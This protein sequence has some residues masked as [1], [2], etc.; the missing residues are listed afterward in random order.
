[1][2]D[3]LFEKFL[4]RVSSLFAVNIFDD[5]YKASW[6]TVVFLSI[7]NANFVCFFAMLGTKDIVSVLHSVTC[8]NFTL[9]VT[10]QW[11]PHTSGV[12]LI[13]TLFVF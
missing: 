5:N 8:M 3:W 13:T 2:F 1:M 6:L 10:E 7:I 12:N 9:Q 11:P 4:G